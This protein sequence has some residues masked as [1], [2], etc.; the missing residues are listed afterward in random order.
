MENTDSIRTGKSSSAA[1]RAMASLDQT[2]RDAELS[3]RPV[4]RTGPPL[5]GPVV[6]IAPLTARRENDEIGY[7]RDFVNTV[8]DGQV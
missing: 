3:S 7:N 6:V 5:T 2:R 8:R 4:T 1:S